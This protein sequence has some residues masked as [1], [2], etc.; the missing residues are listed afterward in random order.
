[1]ASFRP[2]STARR[3]HRATP[4]TAGRRPA[5]ADHVGRVM[6]DAV[7]TVLHRHARNGARRHL[8]TMTTPVTNARA[9]QRDVGRLLPRPKTVTMRTP[10]RLAAMNV[11]HDDGFMIEFV[12]CK[13]I[14]ASR[15]S[16]AGRGVFGT[17]RPS[18]IFADKI[19]C[20]F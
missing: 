4:K 11:S 18:S 2:T 15:Q 6:P 3:V 20:V 12:L 14:N 10:H 1:M 16:L 9:A 5:V 17:P 13:L 7:W 19:P 8:A